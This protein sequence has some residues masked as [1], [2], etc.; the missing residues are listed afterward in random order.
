MLMSCYEHLGKKSLLV[1]ENILYCFH[2]KA[3]KLNESFYL[4]KQAILPTTILP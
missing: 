2:L 3:E 1:Y 4:L